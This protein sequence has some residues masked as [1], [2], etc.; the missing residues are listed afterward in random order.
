MAI[1]P[2]KQKAKGGCP[3]MNPKTAIPTTGSNTQ[4]KAKTFAASTRPGY[5]RLMYA[6]AAFT[7]KLR[8]LILPH[9]NT[10]HTFR[11]LFAAYFPLICIIL[12]DI[13]F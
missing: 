3:V 8:L 7:L 9:H 1:P 12:L 11:K 5:L 10:P 2:S 13:A 4:S 6:I